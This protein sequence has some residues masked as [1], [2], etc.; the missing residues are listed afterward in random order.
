MANEENMVQQHT[1]DE[2]YGEVMALRDL[3]ARRLMDDKV[4]YAAIE[5]LSASNA[6]LVKVCDEKI[7]DLLIR[8]LILLCDRIYTQPTS[9]AF[10]YS[11]LDE[12]LE[13][14]ARRGITP[15][16]QLDTFDPHIHNAVSTVAATDDCPAGTITQVIRHGY[17]SE[18][19]V[20]RPADVIVAVAKDKQ[21]NA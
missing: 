12:L 18:Q 11:V 2:V 7:L 13:I 19:R 1:L 10:A 14:F 15:I 9:D 4:K 21:P 3:F 16:Q 17:A 6:S 8:E 5:K 20:I